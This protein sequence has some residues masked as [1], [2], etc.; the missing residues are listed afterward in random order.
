MVGI[1]DGAT[2]SEKGMPAA[3]DSPGKERGLE[4][5]TKGFP[6]QKGVRPVRLTEVEEDSDLREGWKDGEMGGW[7]AEAQR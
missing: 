5:P 1:R 2:P 7:T 3:E 6:G 4:E